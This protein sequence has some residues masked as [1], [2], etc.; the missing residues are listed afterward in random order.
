MSRDFLTKGINPM[1]K[2][3]CETAGCGWSGDENMR[4]RLLSK[5]DRKSP[6][7][8]WPWTARVNQCGYGTFKIG[9]KNWLAH[10]VVYSI[11]V[12]PLGKF[13]VCHSCDN[14]GCCNP[15][16]LWLGTPFDNARDRVLKNRT[17]IAKGE[18]NGNSKLDAS[19]VIAIRNSKGFLKDIGEKFGV[20]EAMV[21]KIKLRRH[22]SHI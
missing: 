22:W 11:L 7:E 4:Q 12:G 17:F 1:A 14:P 18:L 2:F 6:D 16:H 5:I 13:C 19:D 8:C 20:S 3:R 10:R 15:N 21:S 9:T